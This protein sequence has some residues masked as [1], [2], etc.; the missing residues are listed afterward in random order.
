LFAKGITGYGNS[1]VKATFTP[2]CEIRAL[3][4]VIG[5]PIG[6]EFYQVRHS[7]IN[8]WELCKCGGRFSSLSPTSQIYFGSKE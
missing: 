4:S 2:G 1:R 7:H 8:N 3:T 6:L 5:D